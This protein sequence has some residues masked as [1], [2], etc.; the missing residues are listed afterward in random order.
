MGKPRE[1]TKSKQ[2]L[3]EGSDAERFVQALLSRETVTDVQ[4]QNFGGKDELQGFLK[5]FRIMPGFARVTSLGI[6][7]D[8]ATDPRTAFQSICGGLEGC[9]PA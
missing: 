8:A 6:T 1:I 2:F 9:K 3:V 4:V 5:A 7:R